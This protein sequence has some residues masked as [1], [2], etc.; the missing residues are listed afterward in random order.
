MEC[1]NAYDGN[2]AA[3][4]QSEWTANRETTGAWIR[5][6]LEEAVYIRIVRLWHRCNDKDQMN[7]IIFEIERGIT[8]QVNFSCAEPLLEL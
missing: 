1:N 6:V 3:G 8:I 7:R 4:F 5:V 2:T